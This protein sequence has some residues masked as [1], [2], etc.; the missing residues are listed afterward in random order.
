[1]AT[2]LLSFLRDVEATIRN[3][4]PDPAGSRLK[5]SRIVNYE[6]GLARIDVG[7]SEG[8]PTG[9][10]QLQHFGLADERSCMKATLG[11]SASDFERTIDIF[12]RPEINWGAE[13]NRVAEAWLDGA[14]AD[15]AE[16]LAAS[17]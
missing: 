17:A 8:A 2:R 7:G 9:R 3:T 15:A 12:D 14:P 13:A 1:M 11:W 5:V 6:K 10:I 4:L 16:T